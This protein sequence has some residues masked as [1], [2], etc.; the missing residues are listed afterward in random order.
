MAN[1]S[2]YQTKEG[3]RWRYSCYVLDPTG[4]RKSLRKSGFLTKSEAHLAARLMEV[5][6]NGELS[7]VQ[8]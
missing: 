3:T 7:K 8:N 1:I 2:H 6:L 4:K 5:S